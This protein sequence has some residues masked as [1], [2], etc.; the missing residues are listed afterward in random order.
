ML[1]GNGLVPS[2]LIGSILLHS[3]ALVGIALLGPIAHAALTP[4]KLV[5]VEIVTATPPPPAP[6]KPIARALAAVKHALVPNR[7]P[8]VMPTPAPP[9]TVPEP[10]PVAKSEP[11]PVVKPET[12]VAAPSKA[13][14][15]STV[16]TAGTETFKGG[17][18]DLGRGGSSG[19][20]AGQSLA[21]VGPS[22]SSLGAEGSGTLTSFAIPKGGYQMKPTYPESA[23]RAG[24]EGTSLLR[25]EIT[26]AG[27]V[28]KITVEQSA[29][30]E[31][32]D[33]AAVA[34]IQRWRFE[35]ARRGTQAV[36]VWVTLPIK[37]ELKKH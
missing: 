18:V 32:L 11:D 6:V 8:R 25:F 31:D 15:T 16:P 28:N 23:R 20:R 36:A 10:A 30:H 1:K 7:S 37:F 4:P 17:D 33:R 24:I 21:A 27:M 2:P 13:E 9:P 3:V 14:T 34:A 22:T 29:G 26:E 5:T 35:P 12:P 19:A